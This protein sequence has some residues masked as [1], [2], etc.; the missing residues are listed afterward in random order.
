MRFWLTICMLAF[1]FINL[2]AQSMDELMKR[3]G[4]VDIKGLDSTIVVDLMYAGADNFV[5]ATMYHGLTKAYLHPKAAKAL[6]VAAKELRKV[7]PEYKL[8]VCDASRPMSAQRRMYQTV[9]GTSKAPY[10]SNPARGG[11]LHNYG[12]AVDITIVDKYGKELPMGTK[13][14]YLGKEANIDREYDL[15]RRKVITEDE[16]KNRLLLRSVMRK[17]GFLPLRSEWWH[18][19]YC[20]RREAIA[21]YRILDF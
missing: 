4:M 7:N 12:M 21:K 1:A 10:V 16:R 18:F 5:G 3:Y 14:D 19:N 6:A 2:S 15:V 9:R 13:V 8:K 20:T 17:A 11:G